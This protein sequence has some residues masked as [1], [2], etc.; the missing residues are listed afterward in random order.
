MAHKLLS[1]FRRKITD[2]HPGCDPGGDPKQKVFKAAQSGDAVLLDKVLQEL[3]CSERISV[4]SKQFIN[5]DFSLPEREGLQ[6]TPL[7]V[8]V[9]NG[10]LDCVKVLLKY[11]ADIEGRGD[12]KYKHF[13]NKFRHLSFSGCTPLFVAAVYGNVEILR[14]LLENEAD[15]NAVTHFDQNY[16]TPLMMAIN[17]NHSDAVTFLIDQG[18][19]VNLQTKGGATA[20]HHAVWT[21]ETSLE[22][23]SSLIKNGA[24]V[25]A[26]GGKNK[27]TPLMMAT[28]RGYCRMITFLI[29]HGAYIDLQDSNGRTALHYAMYKDEKCFLG[30]KH[31]EVSKLLAA[32]AS[33]LRDNSGLTPL[34]QA[35]DRCNVL[36]VEHLIKQRE[37]AKEQKIDALELL[38]ASLALVPHKDFPFYDVKEGFEYIKRGMRER[39]ADPSHPLLKQQMEPVETYQNRKESQTLVELAEIKHDRDAIIMESLIIRERILGTNNLVVFPQMLLAAHYFMGS[40]LHLSFLL[41]RNVIKMYL[42]DNFMVLA[43]AQPVISRLRGIWSDDLV[44]DDIFVKTFDQIVIVSEHEMH[45]KMMEIEQDPAKCPVYMKYLRDLVWMISKLNCSR[46]GK[47][48]CVSPFLKTLCKLNPCD[49]SGKSLL[50]M[51]AIFHCTDHCN[52]SYTDA[53]KLLLNAGFNVNS[54]DSN[55]NT[56]L[57][58][59]AHI[60]PP[61]YSIRI[62][63]RIT[64]MLQVFIDEGA[65]HDFVNN[66]GK[67]PMDMAN[68]Y[69]ARRI[70]T[71]QRRK[72]ELQ[73]IA[74]RAVK[75][76]GIPFMGV[77]P[78]TLEKYISMH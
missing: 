48:S 20:L 72:L 51:F 14:C 6:V 49:P 3:N 75:K 41:L 23:V 78:K 76:L 71:E 68:N 5:D 74:A 42:N 56:A 77:V 54:T 18:A 73:C 63:I 28:T 17:Y 10:N 13:T 66:D 65:H 53:T 70:L 58:T 26:R 27:S 21:F 24:D 43:V 37:I 38:G 35:S 62:H 12:I 2:V 67:T 64:D 7:I 30:F 1:C 22:I 16:Y 11:K 55:G 33:H 34:L 44:K 57:H 40:N 61:P 59:I 45:R 29:E 47:L 32:G 50:H 9:Q 15:I 19:D 52:S 4:L 25:N 31:K 69:E 8:A 36:M 39:F 60:S 46:V